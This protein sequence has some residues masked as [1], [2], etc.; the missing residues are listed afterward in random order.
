M[1]WP[2][3]RPGRVDSGFEGFMLLFSDFICELTLLFLD[4]S[5]KKWRLFLRGAGQKENIPFT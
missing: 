5:E 1:A 2:W 4:I 3:H